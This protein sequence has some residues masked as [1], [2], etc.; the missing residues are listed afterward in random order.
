MKKTAWKLQ[1]TFTRI[2]TMYQ[3]I[4]PLS[5]LGPFFSTVKENKKKYKIFPMPQADKVTYLLAAFS[6]FK[7]I[8]YTNDNKQPFFEM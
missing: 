5:K 4:V 8:I 2:W 7:S 3:Y 6:N 1:C